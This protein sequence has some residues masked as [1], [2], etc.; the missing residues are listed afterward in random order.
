MADRSSRE[1]PEAVAYVRDLLQ[2]FGR[3]WFLCGGWAVD[4]WLGRQTRDHAD[5]DIAVFHRDQH[6]IWEHFPNWALVAHDPNVAGDTSEPWNGR[7]LDLPAHIHVPKLGSALSTS[8]A[9]THAAVEFEFMLVERSGQNWV[10]NREPYVAAPSERCIG[11]SSWGLPAETPELILFHKAG[12]DL[13]PVEVASRGHSVR[14]HDEQDFRA[15][16][17]TLTAAQ[18]AWLR[19]ALG[20]VQPG[21][22]WLTRLHP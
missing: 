9:A 16:L 18:R 8:T 21:H 22:P 5:V 4:A 7:Q 10:L 17:P 13:S 19:E 6:A 12:G 15:L 20:S 3:P 2:G 14:P 1:L 11:R